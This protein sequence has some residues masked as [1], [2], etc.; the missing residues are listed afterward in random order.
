M[1]IKEKARV[2]WERDLE[3][4]I[5]AHGHK[6]RGR[7][8]CYHGDGLTLRIVV[9]RERFSYDDITDI[10]FVDEPCNDVQATLYVL[11]YLK[12]LRTKREWSEESQKWFDNTI[13]EMERKLT[14]ECA[15]EEEALRQI[16]ERQ[17]GMMDLL[18][19]ENAELKRSLGEPEQANP[20]DIASQRW[21]YN[22]CYSEITD[23]NGRGL[24]ERRD[25]THEQIELMAAAPELADMLRGLLNEQ[26]RL[27]DGPYR[28]YMVGLIWKLRKLG[29]SD[30]G[31]WYKDG[32]G[33][34]ISS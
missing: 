34:C 16:I 2:A 27:K 21:A 9:P 5:T 12:D 4:E 19:A 17:K 11:L 30:V 6:Y 1:T 10:R 13:A 23:R 15:S 24:V 29:I 7:I 20:V 31:I 25:A 18:Y 8:E 22:K 3:V 33:V 14:A 32:K 28:D 26:A